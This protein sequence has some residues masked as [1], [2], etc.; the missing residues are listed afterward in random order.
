MND[1][2]TAVVTC[3]NYGE[4][5]AEAVKSLLTQE[6]AVP[7]VIV[8]DDGS[9]DAATL[10][11]LDHLPPG[12]ELIRQENQGLAAARN[13]GFR[14]ARTPYLIPLDADDR[15]AVGAL[16]VLHEALER[17][18]SA[19]FAYGWH[20]FFGA[21]S[22]VLRTP[23]Y[24]PYK[25][26]YRHMISSTALMRRELFDDVGGYDPDFR[27]YEDWEFW[28]NS[29]D[30]GWRGRNVGRVVLEVRRHADSMLGAARRDYRHWYRRLRAKHRAV[31]A[32]RSEFARES[33]LGPVGRLVYRG[34]WG[35]RPLPA[36]VE[37]AVYRRVFR[38]QPS[39]RALPPA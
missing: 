32:R 16:R 39:A 9:T 34:F 26:L 2:I 30:H 22:G 7:A 13:A 21:W 24:D 12:V 27:G 8:V 31:Y 19:G 23:P 10:D 15:L 17:D 37:H 4:Y 36:R 6:G 28:I 3:F 20:E 5:L 25:L 35:P 33:D 1:D 18:K 29:L 11:A 14:A 38:A